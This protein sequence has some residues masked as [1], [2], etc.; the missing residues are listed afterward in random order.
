MKPLAR[1]VRIWHTVRWLRPAQVWGQVTFRLRR[2]RVRV[3]SAPA[4]AEHSGSWVHCAREPSMTGPSRFRF[5]GV[6]RDIAESGW[7][8]W[9]RAD[10]PRLWR[11][12]L[13]YFDDL[14]ANGAAGRQE[15]H[16]DLVLLWVNDHPPGAGTAWEPYPV[17]LRIVNWV[18]WSLAA[19][20]TGDRS[21]A[22]R[23]PASAR[24]S[25]AMQARWLMQSLET[26][27]LG[28][29]LWANAKALVFAGLYFAGTEPAAWRSRGLE[30]IRRE[31]GE[32]VLADGGHFELSAMYHSIVLEDL[33]D[34]IQLADRYPGALPGPDI[35]RWRETAER[36]SDWLAVM[37]H[38][39]RD[40][41]L[42][43]DAA[44]GQAP[45]PAAL[46]DYGARLGLRQ[47]HSPREPVHWLRNT[48][49]GRVTLGPWV[50]I[51]D[52]AEIGPSYLPAH[53]HADALT[54]ELS[55]DG[56]R[57][58]VDSGTATYEDCPE[59]W[60]QRSTAAH[61][62]VQVDGLDSSEVWRSFRV[63][64]RARVGTVE[65]QETG[66]GCFV[67]GSHDGYSRVGV[68]RHRRTW[69]F[70]EREL[71]IKDELLGRGRHDVVWGLHLHPDVRVERCSPHEFVLLRRDLRVAR[72]HGDP[73]LDFVAEASR[74]H[75]RFGSSEPATMLIG[76]ASLDVPSSIVARLV[77]ERD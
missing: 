54:F 14:V 13:H 22:E 59:R 37:S 30:L 5:L 73:R 64:R 57:L 60:H 3:A 58:I 32:Q 9:D 70:D 43:N 17:S 68:H 66:T 65:V 71:R 40:I 44:L 2:P 42:L 27:L 75:P 49:Y 31:L 4:V 25:L 77:V 7:I 36:M 56:E 8:D 47:P 53:G 1:V 33:L 20:M 34:L 41:A 28:N 16:R 10:W 21:A 12:H 67:C 23:L 52:A 38:P 50:A 51:L 72:F 76:R 29:H 24:D 62:T 63:A 61:N 48:G 26:H 35:D 6:E 55:L 39:D 45:A 19:D 46:A 18:K 69:S 74:Y 11:Y 15:W